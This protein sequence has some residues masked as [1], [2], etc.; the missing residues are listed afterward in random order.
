LL[1]FYDLDFF[2]G[3]GSASSF[4]DDFFLESFFGVTSSASDDFLD[5]TFGVSFAYFED[6]DGLALLAASIIP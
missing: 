6:F 3:S 4:F 2:I 5:D 1:F